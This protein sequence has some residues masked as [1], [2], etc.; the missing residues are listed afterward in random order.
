MSNSF[1]DSGCV[2][3]SPIELALFSILHCRPIE[4]L[5]VSICDNLKARLYCRKMVVPLNLVYEVSASARGGTF[6]FRH[7][8]SSAPLRTHLH[9]H[10][11]I[12]SGFTSSSPRSQHSSIQGQMGPPLQIK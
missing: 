3:H 7:L 4:M 8:S 11:L 2:H 6:P 10:I 5:D 1:S 9:A 12:T